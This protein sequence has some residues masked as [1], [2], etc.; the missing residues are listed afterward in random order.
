MATSHIPVIMLTAKTDAESRIEGLSSGADAYLE[1]PVRKKLLLLTLSNL[2]KQQMRI[3]EYYAKHFFAGNTD[4]PLNKSDSEFMKK[5]IN[6]IDSNIL[7]PELDVMQ[8]ASALAM[9]HRKLYGKVKALT[10]RSV[11][12]FIRDYRLRKAARMLIEE[13]LTVSMV[14]ERV[15]IDNI[16]Y[17]S[18]IFKKEFGETPSEFVAKRHNSR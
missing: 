15:G 9:S 5:L 18:R 6:L 3:K 13:N 10:G 7:N 11:V 16:S 17:F 14:M 12:E 1:K 4:I 8:V 2:F